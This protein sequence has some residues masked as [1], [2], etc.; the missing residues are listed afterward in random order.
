VAAAVALAA[1]VLVKHTAIIL[2][3]VVLAIA[4]LWWGVKPWREGQ[5]MA[6]WRALL[7]QRRDALAR[8]FLIAL[9]ALWA[10]MLFDVSVPVVGSRLAV[11]G[12]IYLKSFLVGLVHAWA[13][14]EAFL[15]G[16]LSRTGW[17]YYFPVLATYKV[18]IGVWLLSALALVSLRRV[19]PTWGELGLLVPMIA[20]TFLLMKTKIH[21][22]FRH[23]LTPYAFLLA[24]SAR[25]LAQRSRWMTIAA[26]TAAGAVGI[27][28]A[29]FHP[30]Y[31]CY[32]NFPRHKPYLAISDSNVDWGQAL[33]QVR[34][35]IDHRP[36]D[37]RPVYL[38]Y[39]GKAEIGHYL[40]DRVVPV[41][42]ND[43]PPTRGLLI[44]SP[45]YVA[46]LYQ[47]GDAYA[48]LRRQDP[49][50]VIGHSMLVYDL[51]QLGG[52]KPF[53]WSNLAR[54]GPDE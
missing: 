44:I 48:D 52:G 26:W 43:P 30:D 37:G 39:F 13:G 49:V 6:Q 51:D 40:G 18:P 50:D 1:A 15:N 11:P 10:L 24:L 7:P 3:A 16:E 14:H 47:P 32:I 33:K 38:R 45:V 31:L 9:A 34:R 2:P 46:G 28:A 21:I 29:T 20:W 17:W 35:W 23:F 22:G 53:H 5:S 8:F 12:G 42:E 41:G 4:A 25:C 27:H 19:R 36:R 54:P